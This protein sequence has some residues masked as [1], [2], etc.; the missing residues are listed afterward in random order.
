M[1]R[2]R[3]TPPLP[4]G[5]G[6]LSTQRTTSD[7]P[8]LGCA[9]NLAPRHDW[10][11]PG[12]YSSRV[13]RLSTSCTLLMVWFP[14]LSKRIVNETSSPGSAKGVEATLTT[15]NLGLGDEPTP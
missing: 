11:L 8:S 6:P 15:R 9:E 2:K 13:V 7:S 4:A 5:N 3:N 1:Q 12:T 14:T 10:R